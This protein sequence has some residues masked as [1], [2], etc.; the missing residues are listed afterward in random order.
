MIMYCSLSITCFVKYRRYLD[1]FMK[2]HIFAYTFAF[3]AK[4]IFWFA[5]W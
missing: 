5:S 3:I 4:P 1:P 2:S